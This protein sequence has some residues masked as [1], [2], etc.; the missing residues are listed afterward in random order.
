MLAINAKEKYR[1]EVVF[2]DKILCIAWVSASLGN[3]VV[4]VTLRAKIARKRSLNN[5]S[6]ECKFVMFRDDFVVKKRFF[7]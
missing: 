2:A 4:M 6:N 5:L 1:F 7:D 3:R